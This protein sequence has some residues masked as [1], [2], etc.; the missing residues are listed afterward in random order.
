MIRA[1]YLLLMSTLIFAAC[2][3]QASTPP[4]SQRGHRIAYRDGISVPAGT[5]FA[6]QFNNEPP[7]V[8]VADG[9]GP[10]ALRYHGRE[11]PADR[12]KSVIVLKRKEAR[13]RFGDQTIDAAILVE[14][15]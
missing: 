10:L 9:Q 2:A 15:K 8:K 11:L 12:V 5:R 14:L 13:E 3:H 7:I 4:A 6:V 1:D